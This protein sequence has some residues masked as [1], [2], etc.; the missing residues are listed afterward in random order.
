MRGGESTSDVGYDFRVPGD[1]H[2]SLR[3]ESL[4]GK[5]KKQQ[6]YPRCTN[7]PG[8]TQPLPRS[9]HHRVVMEKHG[10]KLELFTSLLRHVLPSLGEDLAANAGHGLFVEV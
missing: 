7:M 9:A 1:R 2:L 4:R 10:P 5:H 6:G 8:R 3:A